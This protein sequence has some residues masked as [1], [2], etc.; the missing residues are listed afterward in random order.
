MGVQYEKNTSNFLHGKYHRLA[1]V[2]F[3]KVCSWTKPLLLKGYLEFRRVQ[4]TVAYPRHAHRCF[5]WWRGCFGVKG[6]QRLGQNDC[7]LPGMDCSWY[8][9]GVLRR[10]QMV[11]THRTFWAWSF[12]QIHIIQFLSKAHICAG[13]F[14]F[15]VN[16][17]SSRYRRRSSCISDFRCE[18][19]WQVVSI[20][21]CFYIYATKRTIV[22][23]GGGG[24]FGPV[25]PCVRR[26]CCNVSDWWWAIASHDILN[27]G[28]MN[29]IRGE[30]LRVSIPAIQPGNA[31]VHYV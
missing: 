31:H 7:C 19:G 22:L 14:G 20:H 26:L 30:S 9:S 24:Q 21:W 15:Q 1:M 29:V 3:D 23:F 18:Y 12:R 11:I 13:G 4:T 8:H 27:L 17:L 25:S 2:S 10:T 5:L 28:I 16:K 6:C